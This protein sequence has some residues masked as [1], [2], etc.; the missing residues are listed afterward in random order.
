MDSL[1]TQHDLSLIKG[2]KPWQFFVSAYFWLS[3]LLFILQQLITALPLMIPVLRREGMELPAAAAYIIT[4]IVV[5]GAFGVS[6]FAYFIANRYSP[7]QLKQRI[8]EIDYLPIGLGYLMVLGIN[9]GV[10]Y[11]LK[12]KNKLISY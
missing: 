6:Y 12:H 11:F 8:K 9:Y 1:R 7:Y 10:Q 5:V 2:F 4:A 3:V